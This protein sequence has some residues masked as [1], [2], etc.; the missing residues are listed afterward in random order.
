MSASGLAGAAAAERR[1]KRLDG[2]R[3]TPWVHRCG[4]FVARYPEL[5][6]RLGN[7]ETRIRAADIEDIDIAKP[8]FVCGLARAGTTILLETLARHPQLG[9][10][11]YRDDPFLFTPLFWNGFLARLPKQRSAPAERA[12][13]D[14]IVVT[15]DSPEAFEEVL[16]MA[17]FRGLHDP[18][19]SDVLDGATGH[20][21]FER[22]FR[23]HLRKLLWVRERPR[24]LS[25]ANYNVTRLEYLLKL[26][27]D[28][29][30]VLPLRDPAAQI[31]SLM[32]QHRLFCEGERRHPQALEHMRR[33]GH[34]EFGLDR[35]PVNVGD[36]AMSGILQAFHDGEEVRGQALY[37]ASLHNWLADRL[38]AN[39][40]LR[41]AVR[42][43]R[44]EDLCG[45][46]R[47]TLAAL[48]DHCDLPDSGALID[49]A[50]AQMRMP[51]YYRPDFT[52]AERATIAEI[53]GPAARRF[54][55]PV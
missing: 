34:F 51:T 18:H 1:G 47:D 29:R 30:F 33:I 11:R 26:F 15:A 36:G 39:A 41:A 38:D 44:F 45:R 35:R 19:S 49:E 54:G 24:Y 12:H 4:S 3:V 48:F 50:A 9:S 5:W 6:I 2:F 25:K 13:A 22:F 28:A 46:P 23:D 17:F 10:H 37:W 53:T 32:K 16:W 27:P 8:V 40:A 31:A 55:Y 21:A 52:E 20:P 14:G 7:L 42:V 43:V